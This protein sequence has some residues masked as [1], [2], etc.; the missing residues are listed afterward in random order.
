MVQA[1]SVLAITASPALAGLGI[2]VALASA[3]GPVQAVLLTEAV[4]GGVP[5]GVRALAGSSLTFASLLLLLALGLSVATPSGLVLRLLNVAGGVLLLWLAVDGFRSRYG[6]DTTSANRRSL[7]PPARGALAIVLNPGAWLFLGAVASPL[8]TSATRSGG[9]GSAVLAGLALGTG[10][11]IG[12][13]GV[14]L[15][16]GLGLRRAGERV[17]LWTQRALAVL[18]AGLGIWLLVQG[19]MNR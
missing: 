8:L 5:R 1:R 19:V 6:V 3:P 7:P 11:G 18:L 17:V 4:R 15:L 16:G 10:A 14:V 12:D 2:G 13:L 9:R